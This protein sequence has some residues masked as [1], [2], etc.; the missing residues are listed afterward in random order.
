M[1]F[2]NTVKNINRLRQ[3]IQILLKYGFEDIVLNTPLQKFIPPKTTLTWTN[4][5]EGESEALMVFST[6][7]ERLRM[8]IEELGPTFV[9][10]AQVLSNRPDF[11]PEALIHEFKKLQNSV[12]PFDTEI[13]KEI[14]FIKNVFGVVFR[15]RLFFRYQ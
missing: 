4:N 3:V 15:E 6:R 2:Q 9:K 8:V 13:A 12:Q 5:E 14:I 1:F 10:L 7:F 11:I